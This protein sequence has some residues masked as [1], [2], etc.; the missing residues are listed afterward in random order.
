MKL[1]VG[2][3][4]QST[5]FVMVLLVVVAAFVGMGMTVH[6]SRTVEPVMQEKIPLKTISMEA[7]LV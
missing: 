3:K 1:N 6:I 2:K 7:L 5:I 4:I